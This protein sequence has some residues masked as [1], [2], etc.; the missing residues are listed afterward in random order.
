MNNPGESRI[1]SKLLGDDNSRRS[2][3]LQLLPIFW[4]DEK[5]DLPR[6]GRSQATH[7]RHNDGT[8]TLKRTAETVDDFVEP[9]TLSLRHLLTCLRTRP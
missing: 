1:A 3:N 2:R 8:V 7:L 4:T 5:S 9:Q 6:S